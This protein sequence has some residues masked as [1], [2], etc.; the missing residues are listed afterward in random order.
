MHK[1]NLERAFAA[2]DETWSPRIAGAVN[3]AH[4]KLAR[5]EGPF[6]WHHHEGEDELFLVIRG[7]LRMLLRDAEGEREEVLEPGE[8]LV[9]PRGTEHCP[10]ADEETHVLLLEPKGTVNTGNVRGERTRDDAWL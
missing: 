1:V 6:V 10:V 3:D 2:I 4:V 5:L 7:R 9:V 8:F